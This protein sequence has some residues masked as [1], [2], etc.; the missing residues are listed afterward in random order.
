MAEISPSMQ[1]VQE[2][3]DQSGL[4]LEVVELPQ[5]TRTAQEAADAV[6]CQLG[7]IVKSLVFRGSGSE[8]PY[9]VL[10][11]GLNRADLERVSQLVGESVRMADA[12]F[13]RAVTGFS[14]GGV[15]PVGLPGS[16][17]TLIDRDLLQ[18]DNI[19]AAAGTPR[20]VFSLSPDDLRQLTAGQVASIR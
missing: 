3:L 19:W 13:V 12:D 14:I 11:S 1:R 5:S 9:L 4:S 8:T 2:A 16:I 15:A 7:Q 10:V 20:S 6:G 18:Y 17:Q